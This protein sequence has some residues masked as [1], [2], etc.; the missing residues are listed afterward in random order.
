MGEGKTNISALDTGLMNAGIANYN[1]IYLS[2]VIPKG[3]MAKIKKLKS[4]K[5]EYG[6]KLLC[7][8][9]TI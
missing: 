6:N 1:L 2:S 7:S 5:D 4:K 3:S 8:Y 9:G